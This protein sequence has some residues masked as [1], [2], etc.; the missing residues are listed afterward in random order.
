MEKQVKVPAAPTGSGLKKRQ[1]IE[2][3]GRS[4][5]VWVA[6]AAVAVSI[7]V[8]TVQFLFQQWSYNNRVLDAKY[9]AADTL[10]KNIDNA[11]KLQDAVNA[12][13]SN[14][15]LA[16]VKTN[17]EDPNTKSV[18]DALPSKFDATALATSLQQAILSRSGVTIE[19]IEV[20]SDPGSPGAGASTSQTTSTSPT[21]TTATPQEMKFTVTVSGSFDKIRSMMLDLERTIRPIKVTDITLNGDDAAMTATV[22]GV[23]YYQPSKSAEIKQE[24][25]K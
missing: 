9:K 8:V 24:V 23:T 22:T 5:F 15:S 3:A 18:L 12:L 17:P 20:P 4:M 1:Q 6:V 7:C 19:G 14:D 25:V 13:V 2:K 11:K 16:S 21:A 10:S